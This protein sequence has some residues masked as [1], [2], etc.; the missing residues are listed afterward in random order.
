MAQATQFGDKIAEKYARQPIADGA[1]YQKK[2]AV[3]ASSERNRQA[4]SS[5]RRT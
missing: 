3:T 5:C 2:L 4:A 1:A